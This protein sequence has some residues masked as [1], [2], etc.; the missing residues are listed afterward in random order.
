MQQACQR[1]GDAYLSDL[2]LGSHPPVRD[3]T[4]GLVQNDTVFGIVV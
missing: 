1:A 3:N 4:L 2:Q